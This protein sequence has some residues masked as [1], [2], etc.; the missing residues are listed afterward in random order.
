MSVPKPPP[1]RQAKNSS[2]L[3]ELETVNFDVNGN[4]LRLGS[5]LVSKSRPPVMY[6][7]AKNLDGVAIYHLRDGQWPV[8]FLLPDEKIAEFN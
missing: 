4:P 5:M 7:E 1:Y 3:V 6:R 8:Y 2:A